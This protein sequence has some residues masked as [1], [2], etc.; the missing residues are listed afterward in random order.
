MAMS[1]QECAALPTGDTAP[2]LGFGS[3]GPAAGGPWAGPGSCWLES[4]EDLPAPCTQPLSS[5]LWDA[6]R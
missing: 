5:L 6:G 2:F 4:I 1:L 3:R